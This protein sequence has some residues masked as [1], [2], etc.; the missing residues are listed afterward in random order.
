LRSDLPAVAAAVRA[1][2]PSVVS[3]AGGA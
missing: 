3:Q 1:W 2:L